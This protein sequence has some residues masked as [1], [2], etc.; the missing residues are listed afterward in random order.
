M[1]KNKVIGN[2]N[3]LDLRNATEASIAEI[4]RI[5]NANLVIYTQ[6]KADMLAKIE[7][8]NANAMMDIPPS[9]NV[10]RILGQTTINRDYFK[11][12]DE[13]VFLIVA[14]QVIIEPDVP[15]EEIQAGLAGSFVMGQMICPDPIA[16]LFQTTNSQVLGQIKIYPAMEHVQIGSF[17]LDPTSLN[18]LEDGTE[19]AVVGSL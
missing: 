10:Q 14:G 9:T 18:A 12:L 4:E 16:G 19:L 13:P 6:G 5:E 8:R 2:V 1:N 17:A 7:V 15:P 11:N 3:I